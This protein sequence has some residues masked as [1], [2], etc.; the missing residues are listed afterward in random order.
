MQEDHT[1]NLKSELAELKRSHVKINRLHLKLSKEVLLANKIL[2]SIEKHSYRNN[3]Q[4]EFLLE[5]KEKII[6]KIKDKNILNAIYNV[7]TKRENIIVRQQFNEFENNFDIDG[8]RNE[9][10][11]K[12]F[13]LHNRKNKHTAYFLEAL[14]WAGIIHKDQRPH[15]IIPALFLSH[16]PEDPLNSGSIKKEANE[17]RKKVRE[18]QEKN[19]NYTL[20]NCIFIVLSKMFTESSS[21]LKIIFSEQT[22]RF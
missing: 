6:L 17:L 3:P 18:A 8:I 21:E 1:Y 5:S 16:N 13:K 20:N 14:R 7:F 19:P 15:M 11:P 22:P 2:I 10:L 4:K 12:G 9:A